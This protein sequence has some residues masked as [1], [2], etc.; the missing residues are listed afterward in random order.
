MIFDKKQSRYYALTAY[1]VVEDV[2]SSTSYIVQPY[3][4][5]PYSQSGQGGKHLSLEEYYSQFPVA[6]IEYSDEKNDLAII[7]FS[8]V[9][10]LGILPIAERD[11]LSSEH[12]AVISNPDGKRFVHSFGSVV[13]ND[14]IAFSAE[15]GK[16]TNTAIQHNAYTAHGSSGSAVLNENMEIVGINIG[17]GTD[18]MGR[19]RYSAM[20]PCRQVRLFLDNWHISK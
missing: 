15:D 3:G 5:A 14:P 6:K 18:F 13:S 17:G 11:A 1:H 16:S 20:I 4:A 12:I 19:Y 9:Q 8:T 10:E 7:S 2:G